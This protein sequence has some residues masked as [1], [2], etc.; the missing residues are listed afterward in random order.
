MNRLNLLFA[1]F[2]E[3]IFLQYLSIRYLVYFLQFILSILIAKSLGVYNF[4][5]WSFILLIVSF[6]RI[7]NFGVPNALNVLYVQNR[8]DKNSCDKYIGSSFILTTLVSIIIIL[9]SIYYYYWG[10]EFIEKYSLGNIFYILCFVGVLIN[11]NNLFMNLAR[12]ENKLLLISFFQS[13]VPLLS[14]IAVLIFRS[15]NLLWALSFTLLFGNLFSLILFSR[16]F[17]IKF[18][19]DSKFLKVVIKKGFHLF[20]Y[21]GSFYLI[22]ISTQTLVSSFYDVEKYGIYGF[23]YT[24]ANSIILFINAIGFLLFPKLI[25]KMKEGVSNVK[26]LKLLRKI[27]ETYITFLNLLLYLALLFFPILLIFMPKYESSFSLFVS[28]IVSFV[29]QIKNIGYSSL[30]ISRNFE[31][32]LSKIVFSMLILNITLTYMFIILLKMDLKYIPLAQFLVYFVYFG[33]LRC[34][35]NKYILKSY[36]NKRSLQPLLIDFIPIFIC[37]III[38][39]ECQQLVFLP[40]IVFVIVKFRTLIKL[41]DLFKNLIN[42]PKCMEL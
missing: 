28:V 11:F 3:N 2:S 12:I 13:I 37:L 21:N 15:N 32:V 24:I 38:H 14:L 23:T 42:N 8:G 19:I 33:L 27:N 1:K 35:V 4:G 5:V 9:L 30:L 34:C 18:N 25:D 26:V 31:R 40:V 39:N 29:F 22:N 36:L 7:V 6:F 41:K 20:I 10:L 17:D 16:K